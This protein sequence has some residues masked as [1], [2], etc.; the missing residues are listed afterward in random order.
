MAGYMISL[1]K[2]GGADGVGAPRY[3]SIDS[4]TK[5]ETGLTWKRW[6]A[7]I[8]SLFPTVNNPL[9]PKAPPQKT[10]EVLF[11]VHGF[12]VSHASAVAAHFDYA[13]K[14]QAQGWDGVLISY[15]WPSDGLV[16][17]YLDDRENAR[18][19]AS[20]LVSAGISQLQGA[21]TADCAVNVHV[22]SHS[23]GGFVTQQAFT[24][25]YQ[26]V[27][28]DWRIGQLLFV[29]ADVD[30]TVFE[31]DNVSAK[32]IVAHAG[33]LTAYCNRYDKALMASNVKRLEL[34]PRMGRVGLPPDAPKAMVEVDCSE[35]F[36]AMF[37]TLGAHLDPQ[38]TH[39]FYFNEVAFWRDVVL[40]LKGGTDRSVIETRN[41]APESVV[42]D[43]Y[44]LLPKGISDDEYRLALSKAT[45]H[46]I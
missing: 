3:L 4:Q 44:F 17:A 19:A 26:D 2:A 6:L 30:H 16:F 34:A 29:A 15:D 33:R 21:Q 36:D 27:P 5:A 11:F 38:A 12:N 20:A 22:M 25:S 23:M 14:L 10:G 45:P 24:W 9:A 42:P 8:M 37:T 43:R 13:A 40:T 41:V 31:A 28:A 7:E 35:L 32:A 18:A 46:A 1:R 39:C